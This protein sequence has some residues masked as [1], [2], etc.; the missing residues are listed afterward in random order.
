MASK[1]TTRNFTKANERQISTSSE[2]R[3]NNNNSN[4]TTTKS[5][6]HVTCPRRKISILL[7]IFTIVIFL[8]IYTLRNFHGQSWFGSISH[9]GINKEE[10]NLV[11]LSNINKESFDP[12]KQLSSFSFSDISSIPRSISAIQPSSPLERLKSAVCFP[13]FDYYNPETAQ[14]IEPMLNNENERLP[15]PAIMNTMTLFDETNK[16]SNNNANSSGIGSDFHHQQLQQQQQKRPTIRRIVFFHMRKAGGTTLRQYLQRVAKFW[17]LEFKVYEGG[18]ILQDSNNNNNDN[19]EIEIPSS[20]NDTLYVTHLR[21]PISRLVSHFNTK[22]TSFL[23]FFLFFFV[24][25]KIL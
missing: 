8:E 16:N 6:Q 23:H 20:R 25:G 9:E 5:K 17:G 15:R 19:D 12:T 2:A 24:E 11:A 3:G 13:N 14:W 7:S 18:L 21:H 1:R 22:I 4:R 10:Y